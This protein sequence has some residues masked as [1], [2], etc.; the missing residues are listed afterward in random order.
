[1]HCA[2]NLNATNALKIKTH[3]FTITSSY[4]LN[5]TKVINDLENKKNI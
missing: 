3:Q 1:M 5:L 2:D 4:F